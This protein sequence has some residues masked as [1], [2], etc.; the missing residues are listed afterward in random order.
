MYSWDQTDIPTIK[1]KRMDN[2]FDVFIHLW[3]HQNN[4]KNYT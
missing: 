2:L 3:F 4:P 1:K